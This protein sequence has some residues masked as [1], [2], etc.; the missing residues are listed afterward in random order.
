[1]IQWF[2]TQGLGP[3]RG[4]Q[5]GDET[6]KIFILFLFSQKAIYK[7]VLLLLLFTFSMHNGGQS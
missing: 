5:R 6:I 7:C 4:P 3:P 2:Q 1:M